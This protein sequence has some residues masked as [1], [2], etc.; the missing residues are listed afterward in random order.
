MKELSTDYHGDAFEG[1][2]CRKKLKEADALL[3]PDIYEDTGQL[4][5]LPFMNTFKA[6]SKLVD[7]RFSVNRDGSNLIFHV[8][9]VK[10]C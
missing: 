4:W 5:L 7:W 2:A 1:N 6:M 10:K 9:N 3:D 8:N